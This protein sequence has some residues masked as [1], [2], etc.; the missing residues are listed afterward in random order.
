[1]F[2]DKDSDNK[3]EDNALSDVNYIALIIKAI[4]LISKDINHLLTIVRSL[5][6][7]LL[8]VNYMA[9][10]IKNTLISFK[11][12]EGNIIT[13]V[14]LIIKRELIFILRRDKSLESH[15]RLAELQAE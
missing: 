13:E 6:S 15:Y 11:G 1:V 8:N 9:I 7:L 10:T 12:L 3:G 14:K 2:L 5:C 4:P